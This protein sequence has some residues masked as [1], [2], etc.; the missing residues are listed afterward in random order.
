MT[1]AFWWW[2]FSFVVNTVP[3]IS[4]AKLDSKLKENNEKPILLVDVRNPG[5]FQSGHI[6]NAVNVPLGQLDGRRV[7]EMAEK[8]AEE[9]G[10]SKSD[11]EVVCVCLSAHR[12][13]PAVRL[14]QGADPS[15]NVKQL[16]YGMANWWMKKFE[17]IKS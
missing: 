11:V 10:C 4:A 7:A 15:L 12:S 13:P 3:G 9:K 14:I 5:E 6:P 17:T 1:S 8:L 16:D 2:P